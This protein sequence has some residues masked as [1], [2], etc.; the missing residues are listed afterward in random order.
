MAARIKQRLSAILALALLSACASLDPVALP[1][2]A[3]PPP[4]AGPAW[5]ALEEA[6]RDDWFALLNDG[7]NALD[8]RLRAIDSATERIDLQ[9]FLWTF[10]TVGAAVLDHLLAAADRGVKVKMLIDDTFLLGEDAVLLE[11]AHHP[12]IEYRVFNPYKRRADGFATR[13]ALNLA[14]F[15]RLDHRMHN[16]AMIVDNRIAIVGGRNIADEYFGLH[17]EANF[18][19]L[20]VIVGGPVVLEVSRAF[21]SYWNDRWAVPIESLSHVTSAAADLDSARRTGSGLAHVHRE[22]T[23]H[24][25]LEQWKALAADAFSARSRL[26][27][28]DPPAENPALASEVPVQVADALVALFDSARE[29]IVIVTAYLIPTPEL[30]RAVE[31]AV[32]RGVRVR[33]LTNSIGSNNHLTAHSAY[34]NH[35]REILESGADMHEVRIDAESRDAYMLAPVGEKELMLHS[36]ALIVDRDKV[37][38]G[39]PNLDPRSLRINTEMG[40]LIES[41]ALNAGLRAAIDPDFERSNAWELKLD[42]EGRVV[43]ISD[44]VTLTRQPAVSTWQR[45][46]DWFF[47]HLPIEDEL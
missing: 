4:A 17:A 42:D 25:R 32:D 41:E 24:A 18:R 9:T 45:I 27:V 14:E 8:W 36:K 3:T 19:D 23:P 37:F 31:H 35:I 29:E 7:P 2:E 13:Q 38:I 46:E 43:W 21:D 16:K 44:E 30:A 12:N 1:P 22:E 20:E 15:H 5:E 47:A 6:R 40:F 34:R 26:L 28:D 10:D 39:S 33:M 11:I